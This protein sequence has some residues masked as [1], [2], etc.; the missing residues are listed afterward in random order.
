MEETS[1]N[2]AATLEENSTKSGQAG[3]GDPNNPNGRRGGVKLWRRIRNYHKRRDRN[4]YSEALVDDFRVIKCIESR[5]LVE[6][7]TL[8]TIEDSDIL[9]PNSVVYYHEFINKNL[10]L[11][12][13]YFRETEH[14]LKNDIARTK[15]P[16]LKENLRGA[17]YLCE[18]VLIFMVTNLEL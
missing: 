12:F 4:P 5:F 14:I 7:S 1:P 18:S 15:D 11:M 8:T 16:I 10:R 9:F 17:L 3:N 2:S 6:D 13:G